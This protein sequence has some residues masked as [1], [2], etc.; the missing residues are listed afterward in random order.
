MCYLL[1]NAILN[2]IKKDTGLSCDMFEDT[3]L[4]GTIL[5]RGQVLELVKVINLC[6]S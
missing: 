1:W 5:D 2:V 3:G 6:P 4:V